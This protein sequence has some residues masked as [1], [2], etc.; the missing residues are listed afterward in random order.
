MP[1]FGF[2]GRLKGT[3]APGQSGFHCFLSILQVCNY[4][5]NRSLP[6]SVPSKISNDLLGT[7]RAFTLQQKGPTSDMQKKNTKWNQTLHRQASSPRLPPASLPPGEFLGHN[8]RWYSPKSV[9]ALR[10]TQTTNSTSLI[11]QSISRKKIGAL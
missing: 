11:A 5:T 2:G 7:S 1:N 8:N 3:N 4:I 9:P 6:Y 10:S